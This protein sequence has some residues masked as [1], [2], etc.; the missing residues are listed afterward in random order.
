MS[1]FPL[2]LSALFSLVLLFSKIALGS[3]P[4]LNSRSSTETVSILDLKATIYDAKEGS[5]KALYL[6]E[7]HHRK[8][9]SSDFYEVRFFDAKSKKPAALEWITYENGI[10]KEYRLEHKQTGENSIVINKDGN[11]IL[12]HKKKGESNWDSVSYPYSPSFIVPAQILDYL[13]LNWKQ[14]K[15][16]QKLTVNWQFRTL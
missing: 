3:E 5:K 12:K 16:N 9:Q 13:N 4:K 1:I 2:L 11:L 14:L 7:R 8:A 15:R 6:Y 10:L